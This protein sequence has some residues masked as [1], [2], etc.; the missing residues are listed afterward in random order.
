MSR[1]AIHV[2]LVL[3]L[4]IGCAGEPETIGGSGILEADEMIVSAETE[5]RV[6]HLNFN[7]GSSVK[8]GDT[9][10]I[11]D[12]SRLQ[13]KL[14]SVNALK[15]VTSARLK[16]AELQLL[17][18]VESEGFL[19]NEKKRISTLVESGTGTTKQL[20]QI[21]HEFSQASLSV[22]AARVNI[23]TLKAE[24]QRAVV[25]SATVERMIADCY[26]LSA[27][28]GIVTEKY[29]EQGELLSPGKPIARISNLES[30]TVKVYLP[31]KDF[32]QIKIG[33]KATI[34]IEADTTNYAAEVVW[35]SEEAEFTPK[36]IQT[37]KSRANL[38]YAVKLRILNHN[39]ILKIGMPVYISF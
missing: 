36:N 3:S 27:M 25:D 38:V 21:S 6:E 39:D 17:Q 5:G 1:F 22:A 10:A 14:K 33:D 2:L 9:L 26:P 23:E 4:F 29:V 19:R 31:R 35:T 7:E 28:N 30:L 34:D 18:S 11:I 32:A 20:D 16:A 37:K 24:L 13:L 8:K 15:N 12:T